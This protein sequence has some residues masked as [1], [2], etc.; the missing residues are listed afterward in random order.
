M[1]YQWALSRD[2]DMSPDASRFKPSRHLTVDGKLKVPFFNHMAFGH[3]RRI[4]PGRWFAEDTLWTAA[5]TIRTVLR[6]DRAKDSNEDRIEVK[7][8]FTTGLAIHP[9]PFH[10]S[11][12][13]VNTAREG[14]IRAMM[15]SK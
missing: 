1:V 10:C 9:E 14:Y 12:E 13:C 15:N 3:G 8:E 4:C 2:E 6:A 5:A 11:F 7:L